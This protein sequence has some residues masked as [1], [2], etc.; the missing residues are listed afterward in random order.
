MQTLQSIIDG[1]F[2]FKAYVMLPLIVLVI[3]LIVRMKLKKALMA[4]LQ[5]AAGFAGIFIAFDFFV[6]NINPAVQALV[7]VRGLDL[8]VLDVGWP[9]LAAITWA[10]PVAHISIPLIIV[11]NIVMLSTNLTKTIYIDIWNYWHFALLGALVLS[12]SQSLL[13]GL[14]ATALIAIYTIKMADWTGPLVKREMGMEGI[15]LSPLSA[16]GLLPYAQGLDWLYDHIPGLRKLDYNPSK[17]QHEPSVFSE[18]MVIG[19]LV[20]IALGLA[21]AYPLKEMLELS[22]HI[23]AVM[24]ILPKCGN[25]IGEGMGEIS[26]KL[27]DTIHEKFPKKTGLYIALDSGVVMHNQS[28][29]TTG[30]ILMPIAILIA[31]ILPGNKT[32]PLGDLPALIAQ[33]A[34]IVLVSRGNVLRSVL[35]GIPL[36][37]GYLLIATNLAP[38]ITAL[39]NK[40]GAA[41]PDGV[42]ITAMTDGGNPIRYWGLTLFQG[43][44]VAIAIIP[45]MILLLVLSHSRYKREIGVIAN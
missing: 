32:L 22:I 31:L 39:S 27:R 45:I 44:L 35:T 6:A 34:V 26:S 16:V 9:P 30:I 24:F 15:T 1:F 13:L 3:G 23:A 5:L 43:N 19:V 14:L 21:A 40:V 2:Q 36:V 7:Q 28:I 11:I 42:L 33:V 17:K 10:S 38:M 18:P 20:G 37:I 25:L 12:V 4:S 8:P 29:L 41:T